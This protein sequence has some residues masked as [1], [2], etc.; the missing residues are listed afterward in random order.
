MDD[1]APKTLDWVTLRGNCSVRHLFAL[2]LETVD[3]DVTVMQERLRGTTRRVECDRTSQAK[4]VVSCFEHVR[5]PIEANVVFECS[6]V[7]IT[8]TANPGHR[9]LFV[10]KPSF[11]F[12][13]DCALEIDGQPMELWQV[14]R[15][16]LEDLFFS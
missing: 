2:L 3:S 10:A 12:A 1:K 6:Y 9:P 13:G 5:T 15:K 16:A 14:S 8:V 11:T 4:F 7:A